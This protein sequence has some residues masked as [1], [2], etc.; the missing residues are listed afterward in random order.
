MRCGSC[1]GW[2]PLTVLS[3]FL[4]GCGNAQAPSKLV[5]VG[6]KIL[7]RNEPLARATISFVPEFEQGQAPGRDARATVDRDGHFALQTYPFGPGAMPGKY[8]VFVFYYSRNEGIPRKYTKF[9]QTP[10]SAEVKEDG[11]NQFEFRI[12]D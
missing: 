1:L 12:R 8:K 3:L 11:N 6:G 4:A 2:F 7:Y 9:H 10:L 5:P